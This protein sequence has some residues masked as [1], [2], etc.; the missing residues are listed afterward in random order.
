MDG[1]I[2]KWGE[3]VVKVDTLRLYKKLLGSIEEQGGIIGNVGTLWSY[4]IMEGKQEG[5]VGNVDTISSDKK[6][7]NSIGEKGEIV[8]NVDTEVFQDNG[9]IVLFRKEEGLKEM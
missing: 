7:V 9:S 2:K 3:T 1:S 4:R 5:I 6:I 8:G